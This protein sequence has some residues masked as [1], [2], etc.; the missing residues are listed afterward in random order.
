MAIVPISSEPMLRAAFIWRSARPPYEKSM[1]QLL[2]VVPT[3]L[4]LL[5]AVSGAAAAD[6]SDHERAREALKAGEIR[7]LK[8]IVGTVQS[9]CGGRV[10]EVELARRSRDGRRI[11]LYQIRMLTP[12]GDVLGLDVNAATT[13]I[14]EVKG[15]GAPRACQ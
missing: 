4:L 5:S 11:W 7:P 1:R 2:A 12:K 10:I 6:D 9:R 14:L 15:R 13:E 3:A 8:D